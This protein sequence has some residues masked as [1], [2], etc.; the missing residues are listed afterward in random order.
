MEPRVTV[1]AFRGGLTKQTSGAMKQL[2][3]VV[4]RRRRRGDVVKAGGQQ[5]LGQ[6]AGADPLQMFHSQLTHTAE[7]Q[8]RQD[9]PSWGT[10]EQKQQHYWTFP[11]I[12]RLF[13]LSRF[14]FFFFF[15]NIFFELICCLRSLYD[16]YLQDNLYLTEEIEK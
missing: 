14:F 3:A 1:F 2:T 9:L 12:K 7:A 5:Q 6:H 16:K 13:F 4:K 11:T 10:L 8:I 15:F